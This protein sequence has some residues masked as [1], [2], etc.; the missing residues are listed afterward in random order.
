MSEGLDLIIKHDHP[1]VSLFKIS[2]SLRDLVID[3]ES[4]GEVRRNFIGCSAYSVKVT[5][6]LGLFPVFFLKLFTNIKSS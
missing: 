4:S 5:L 1:Y 2:Q 6:T 3:C